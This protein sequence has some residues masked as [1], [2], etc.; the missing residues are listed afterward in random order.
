VEEFLEGMQELA[1]IMIKGEA[2]GGFLRINRTGDEPVLCDLKGEVVAPNSLFYSVHAQILRYSV[3]CS[4]DQADARIA[5]MRLMS[6]FGGLVIA[7]LV[8][9]DE[10][11]LYVLPEAFD[12]YD[13]F[14]VYSE[15][16]VGEVD[17]LAAFR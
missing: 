10:D 3:L 13:F 11:R 1:L 2:F 4:P 6:Q 8:E 15:E 16:A 7:E 17:E 5:A 14:P 12:T 9:L